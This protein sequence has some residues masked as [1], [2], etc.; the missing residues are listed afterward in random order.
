[1]RKIHESGAVVI[2]SSLPIGDVATQW[3]ADRL[4]LLNIFYD[5]RIV[6]S[7]LCIILISYFLNYNFLI[8]TV[9][10]RYVLRW[11]CRARRFG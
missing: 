7:R 3:F 1:M 11:P 8:L 2:I 4:I 6:L 9:F 5:Y 10:E